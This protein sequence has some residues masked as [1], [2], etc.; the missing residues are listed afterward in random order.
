LSM[1]VEHLTIPH[2][3]DDL[4]YLDACANDGWVFL[5]VVPA[6]TY[7]RAML[8]REF[9]ASRSL[10]GR[11]LNNRLRHEILG[12]GGV[13][14]RFE[15]YVK[16]AAEILERENPPKRYWALDEGPLVR[17]EDELRPGRLRISH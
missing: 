3:P 14:A 5:N 17:T 11:G 9:E 10:T 13:A 12:S 6:G 15:E 4:S 16:I 7:E 2:D 1:A 8:R